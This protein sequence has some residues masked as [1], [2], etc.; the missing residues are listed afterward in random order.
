MGWKVVGIGGV[1]L[2][3]VWFGLNRFGVVLYWVYGERCGVGLEGCGLGIKLFC[4]GVGFVCVFGY[5][6]FV[7]KVFIF[8]VLCVGVF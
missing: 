1:V 8:L 3:Q 2:V 4:Y 5:I 6:L 7:F